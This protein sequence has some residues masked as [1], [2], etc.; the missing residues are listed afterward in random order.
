MSA[1]L[2]TVERRLHNIFLLLALILCL[3]RFAYLRADF[4]NHSPWVMDQ[5]KFT[6]EGWWASAAVRH[7]LMGHWQVAGDYNPAAAVPVWPA[8]LTMVFHFTGVS[9]VAARA[10]NV[11]FS[12]AT[13]GLV[14]LLARRYGGPPALAALLLAASPFAFA[15]SRLATLDTIIVFEF[16]LLLWIASYCNPARIWPATM[17]GILIPIM[18][19]TKTTAVVLL[20]AVLW[21]L[22]TAT[23]KKFLQAILLVG[24]V[25]GAGIGI[26]LS[27][28]LRSR[29]ADDYHYFFDINALTNVEWGR[30]ASFL[31]QLSR[32]GM[33][34][35]RV[36]Y[37]AALVVL[38]LSLVWLRQLWRNPLFTASWIAFAGEAVYILRRQDDFA[39]RYFLAMLVPLILVV[40][41][42]LGE[43]RARNRSLASLLAATL[44]LALVLDTAQV[45]GFLGHRQYQFYN[46]AESIKRIVDADPNAHRL[47]LG[48]SGDQ[49][50]LMMG[51]PSI[52]DGYSSQDLGPKALL[53]QPGWYVGWNE[54]DQDIVGSLS[55]FRLDKVAAFRV[56]D[57]DERDS[58]T[59]YRIVHVKPSGGS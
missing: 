9:I 38:M 8:L 19:L 56:F 12:I 24:A 3:M 22:W 15:F 14:Y 47:L 31:L 36:L 52:N 16:C 13:V 29:Y 40:V 35:D 18:L 54:L 42:A 32:H 49:L 50:S 28:V 25:A 5:A 23:K 39:P 27:I 58:L 7:F 53:Y 57:H 20:P 33:W 45:V 48:S 43:L 1:D 11:S 2:K 34:I 37:P 17:L 51:V 26:Y 59:L 44:A 55:A 30:S 46:A 4:P 41:L 10:V 21:L 6:D